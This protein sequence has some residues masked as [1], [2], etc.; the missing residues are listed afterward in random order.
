MVREVLWLG[1]W[2][3][4]KLICWLDEFSPSVVFFIGGDS[5]F[6]HRIYQYIVKR[7]KAKSALYLTDDYIIP[8]KNASIFTKIR[9]C[10]IKKSIKKSLDY[11]DNFFTISTKMSKA[12]YHIFGRKSEIIVNMTNSLKRNNIALDK[13]NTFVYAG[14]LYY[15]R[16]LVLEKVAHAI[17]VYNN[18]HENNK[19]F[20]KIYSNSMPS[21]KM[22]NMLNKDGAS[23]FCGSLDYEQLIVEYNKASVLVFVESYDTSQIEKT[24]YSLSTKVPEYLSVGKPILAIGPRKIGSMEFVKGYALCVYSEKDIDG[25]VAKL[26]EDRNLCSNLSEKALRFYSTKLNKNVLQNQFLSKLF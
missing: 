8:R 4:K 20:L 22:L 26:I 1:A 15:G 5:L 3:S 24:K 25:S 14:S 13:K 6:A 7:F 11:S 12:Y 21:N 9:Q 2:K 19:A 17:K 10:L 16:E 18:S 23:K